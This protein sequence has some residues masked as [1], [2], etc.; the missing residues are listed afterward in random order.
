M[1]D[2]RLCRMMGSQDHGALRGC[3]GRAGFTR[4][5]SP[6]ISW[7]KPRRKGLAQRTTLEA[8]FAEPSRPEKP[9]VR[10]PK[11]SPCAGRF[12]LLPPLPFTRHLPLTTEHCGP[13]RHIPLLEFFVSL[14]KSA[15]YEFLIV[16]HCPISHPT[17][18]APNSCHSPISSTSHS[19]LITR[20]RTSNRT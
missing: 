4:C 1:V 18:C 19:P 17:P 13:N 11:G 14:T 12:S 15:S 9:A 5:V 3:F 10:A 8:P 6:P 16:T 20:H 2:V 7:R